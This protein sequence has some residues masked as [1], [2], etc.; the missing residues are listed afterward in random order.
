MTK[1][2]L[3]RNTVKQRE[4]TFGRKSISAKISSNSL[5]RVNKMVSELYGTNRSDI[6]EKAI[7]YFYD[8]FHIKNAII[9]KK[10]CLQEASKWDEE[11][12][13]MVEAQEVAKKMQ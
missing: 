8:G 13:A 3:N 10:E 9:R 12:K 2:T 4:K 5:A 11:I 7:N 1:E 6:I